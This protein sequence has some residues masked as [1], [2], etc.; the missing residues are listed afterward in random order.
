MDTENTETT[1]VKAADSKQEAGTETV[2]DTDLTAEVEKW[3]ALARKHEDRAKANFEKAKQFDQLEE[4]NKSALQKVLERAEKA[5]TALSEAEAKVLRA[6]VA[7]SKGVPVALLHGNDPDS[8]EEQADAI[9]AFKGDKPDT[10][11]ADV[12]AGKGGKTLRARPRLCPLMKYQKSPRK[13]YRRH[14]KTGVCPRP[15]TRG[16]IS[17]EQKP[18]Q[19]SFVRSGTS[20]T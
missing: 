9:L 19:L 3:K 10:P 15:R 20:S 12:V 1:E 18:T 8:L 6:E 13:M 11:P 16:V 5:E 17:K 4:A 7:A 2:T 14:S